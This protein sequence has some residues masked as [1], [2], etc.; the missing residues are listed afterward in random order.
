MITSLRLRNFRRYKDATLPFA[1][2]VNFIEGANNVGKTTLLYAIEY[3]L[4]GRVEGFKSLQSLLHPGSKRF[5]IELRFQGKGGHYL[6]QRMH[7]RPPRSRN[8]MTGHFTLKQLPAEGEQGERYLLS[9]DFEDAEDKLSLKI[10]EVL[11]ITRRLFS[12]AV[13]MRQGDIAEILSGASQLDI[14]LGV[15]AAAMAEEELRGLALE[16]EKDASALPVIQERLRGIAAETAQ[17]QA[18]EATLHHDLSEAQSQVQK[19]DAAPDLRAEMEAR[20]KPLS[21]TA[22]LLNTALSTHERAQQRR[23]DEENRRQSLAQDD[24][25]QLRQRIDSLQAESAARSAQTQE[26]RQEI[27]S[28]DQQRSGL[29]QQAG[30]LSGRIKRRA[31]LPQ[32]DDALCEACG[33]PI[34]AA[35]NASEVARWTEELNALK[36]QIQELQGQ[37]QGLNQNVDS[38]NAAEKAAQTE[39]SKLNQQLSTLASAD[40]ALQARC[41]EEQQAAEN[42][43]NAWR[44]LQAVLRASL[45]TLS[46]I[47]QD[48]NITPT[49]SPA[50]TLRLL[51][52]A[53]SALRQR[54]AEASGRRIAEQQ[55][56]HALLKRLEADT[57]R[58]SQRQGELD[59]EG[60]GLG[61]QASALERKAKRAERFRR[62]SF[63]FKQLQMQIRNDASQALASDVLALHRK[64]SG[65][66]EEFTALSID[67]AKYTVQVVP[68][69]LGEEVPAALY[70]GGGHR[71]L[72][73]L[74]FRL[75]VVRMVGTCPFVLLDEPTYGLDVEHR[76]ALLNRISELNLSPQ[77]LLITHQ[78]MGDVPG[79]RIKVARQGK[80]TVMVEVL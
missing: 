1:P 52:D 22:N 62:L 80:E 28:L 64:L 69:D 36:L 32:G 24:P 16:L 19:L 50:E 12:V 60:A 53:L 68:H 35:H 65:H 66:A 11:G 57:A 23:Q 74:A 67:P 20:L 55:A 21:N 75:A 17:I 78:A 46:E 48:L 3:A 13:N 56:A 18:Q 47:G 45:A 2:G 72:L 77:I 54:I 61:T 31:S 76:E 51:Q 5:G 70:E 33:A 63:G 42:L 6:L 59:R 14:V 8:N 4:F 58:L 44:D 7:E 79:R 43:A 41:S 73:G 34:D 40:A 37:R 10:Q 25:D 30:D 38:K 29:D 9:S 15:T 39:I 71:L 49:D 26:L 27:A